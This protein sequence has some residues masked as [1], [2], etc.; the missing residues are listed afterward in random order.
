[1]PDPVTEFEEYR[2]ELLALLGGDDPVAVLRATLLDVERLA[3]GAASDALQ[4]SA[5]PGEWSPR[6]VL[7]HLADSEL[8]VNVRVRMIV[9]Q[10]QPSLVGYD[11]EAWTA[12]F[13]GLG[14]A[15][16]TLERFRVLRQANLLMFESLTADEWPRV[17]L[18][19]ERGAESALLT[20]QMA[21]GH[22]RLHIDQLRR[23]LAGSA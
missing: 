1:M 5:S 7:S 15:T 14:T 3:C 11:Q 13:G 23:G 16:E 2:Q 9:T 6:E 20:V 12:R 8:I 22:D 4:R 10:E 17:G 18:H 21:A 19:S